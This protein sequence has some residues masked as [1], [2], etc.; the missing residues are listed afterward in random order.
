[1]K[2][3]I[4]ERAE[5]RERLI[6]T[7]DSSA[8][9]CHHRAIHPRRPWTYVPGRHKHICMGVHTKHTHT[10]ARKTHTSFRVFFNLKALLTSAVNSDL[11]PKQ[12]QRFTQQNQYNL[13]FILFIQPSIHP[14]IPGSIHPSVYLFYPSSSH[15]TIHPSIHHILR[16]VVM[17]VR[18]H[19]HPSCA[20]H[21]SIC[22]V[23]FI[24][25]VLCCT[26]G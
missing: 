25:S 14:S 5:Q 16:A 6:H 7:C 8:L 17:A 12:T 23:L 1:M 15:P 9:S 10:G 20:I 22:P 19:C 18:P 4:E 13:Q 3:V 2:L 26:A 21:P 24:D 11:N